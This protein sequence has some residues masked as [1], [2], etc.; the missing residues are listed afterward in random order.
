MDMLGRMVISLD[1][2]FGVSFVYDVLM[3]ELG[4]HEMENTSLL[5]GL[6]RV[7]DV[8]YE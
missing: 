1:L 6:S 2:Y 4:G 8:Q 3:Y 7:C 5:N